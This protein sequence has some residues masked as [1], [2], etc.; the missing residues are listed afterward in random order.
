M[1]APA[2]AS[3]SQTAIAAFLRDAT[4]FDPGDIRFSSART[5]DVSC[6]VAV[7]YDISA[8]LAEETVAG[9]AECGDADVAVASQQQYAEVCQ[10]LLTEA[11]GRFDLMRELGE[12]IAA[13][14]YAAHT[15]S[16]EFHRSP[17]RALLVHACVTC[18]GSGSVSCRGCGGDGQVSCTSCG[19]MGSQTE[20]VWTTDHKGD[21]VSETRSVSC[22]WCFGGRVRCTHCGGSGTET[23]G[24]CAGTG[25][26]TRIGAPVLLAAPDYEIDRIDPADEPG[27]AE[28][29]LEC[30]G[31]VRLEQQGLRLIHRNVRT[32]EENRRICESA[33]FACQFSKMEVA[34]SSAHGMVV[35]FGDDCRISDA[36]PLVES[37]VRA[38]LDM[39][40]AAT[41]RLR[42]FDFPMLRYTQRLATLVMQSEVHQA[43]L[44]HATSC[45]GKPSA[46]RPLA[47]PLVRTLSPGYLD[48]AVDAIERVVHW[49]S[50]SHAYTAAALGLATGAALMAHF[51]AGGHH[52]LGVAAAAAAFTVAGAIR[53]QLTWRRLRQVGGTC[54]VDFAASRGV[55]R[56][57][58]WSW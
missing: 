51:F 13:Q 53:W 40:R 32:E 37:M 5:F 56:R 12:R 50:A 48:E 27:V 31:L 58:S 10:A 2:H 22:S 15:R 1:S 42:R 41:A 38:D 9:G 25:N 35:T 55:R 28:A 33:R 54:L 14:R 49:T 3:R 57:S 52:V 44:A 47:A 17:R 19:G 11:E 8:C 24:G 7:R 6:T 23:C 20:T 46:G 4:R 34:T 16:F 26:Q 18:A 43:A 39:L 21:S 29:L 36:G 45:A 30:A